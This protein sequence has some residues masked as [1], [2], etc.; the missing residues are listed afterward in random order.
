MNERQ[1]QI[2]ENLRLRRLDL[3]ADEHKELLEQKIGSNIDAIESGDWDLVSFE[4]VIKYLEEIK[5][6]IDFKDRA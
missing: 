3:I 1:K 4:T 2:G 5:I 6:D